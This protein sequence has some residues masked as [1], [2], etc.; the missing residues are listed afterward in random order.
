[1]SDLDDLSP[2]QRAWLGLLLLLNAD[3]PRA[4]GVYISPASGLMPQWKEDE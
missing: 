4:D 2:D 1:V 3:N